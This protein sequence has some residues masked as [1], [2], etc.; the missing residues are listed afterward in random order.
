MTGRRLQNQ[1]KDLNY[2][3]GQARSKGNIPWLFA[4]NDFHHR[5]EE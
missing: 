5:K 2:F 1:E 3:S 4:K